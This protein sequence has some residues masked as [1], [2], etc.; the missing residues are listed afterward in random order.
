MLSIAKV[1][2]DAA[3]GQSV[4]TPPPTGAA[5]TASQTAAV[6]T[7]TRRAVSA[8]IAVLAV[9]MLLSLAS[10]LWDWSDVIVD[11]EGPES[12]EWLALTG[13]AWLP[14]V[15]VLAYRLVRVN[16]SL[17]ETAQEALDAF[18]DTVQTA[19]G[20][21]WRIDPDHR[22]VYSSGGIRALLGHEPDE[23]IGRN[24]FDLL[25]LD[26]D[27]QEVLADVEASRSQDGW[28]NWQTRVRHR[29][30]SV[31]HVRSSATPVHGKGGR[32]IAYRGFTADVTNEVATGMAEQAEQMRRHAIKTRIEQVILDPDALRIAFQP[33]IDVH[34]RRI[35]GMEALSRFAGEPYRTP[36]VWFDE[37]WQA[38]LGPELELH[39]ITL[40]CRHLDALPA[41]AYLSI[42]ASPVTILDDRFT[43]TLRALHG[44]LR[45]LV[46]EIT[47]HAA[48]ADYPGLTEAVVGLRDL[49]ARLAVDDA[50]AGYASMQHILRLRPDIIKLDRGIVADLDHDVA[51]RALVTAMAGFAASLNMT[52]VAEG[53]ETGEELTALRTAGIGHAQGYLLARPSFDPAPQWAPAVAA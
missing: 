3:D 19:N 11:G 15:G 29:D 8:A 32:L 16:R 48:V 39:A 36:D 2:C 35:V 6:F 51:R 23:V 13:A 4:V 41:D 25:I 53:V 50:G 24:A 31:R 27:R 10:Y 26:E 42:N 7:R 9:S 12:D 40:A 21:V 30:G 44:D 37:A 28:Q 17:A 14:V 22:I 1:R 46:V 38:G 45:Q 5:D 49:G 52:V 34:A 47:E 33:I 20:W 18:A 43:A